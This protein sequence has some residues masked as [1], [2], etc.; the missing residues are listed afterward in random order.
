MD[1]FD[2]SFVCGMILAPAVFTMFFRNRST[3][4]GFIAAG[5]RL[6]RWLWIATAA[7]IAA[8]L[9]LARWQPGPAYFLWILFFPLWFNLAMPLLRAR[10]PGWRAPERGEV[11]SA[12]LLRRDRLQPGLRLAWFA[13]VILWA[14]L[15]VAAVAGLALGASQPPQWWLLGFS[16]L[17]GLELAVLHWA[18]RRSL[19]E[20]ETAAPGE[21][22]VLRPE[23]ESF[24]RY[25]LYGWFALAFFAMLIFSLP[26]LILIWFGNDALWWAI[27][28]GGGGGALTGIGGGVFGS[29]ASIKR[30]R[31]NRLVV[32]APARD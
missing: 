30:A 4:P 20:P 2:Y 9:L 15:L 14:L 23:R 6:N 12:S 3:E 5:K 7:G 32:E 29:I 8:F 19:I 31:I 16:L 13:L 26:P 21:S 10:D 25:K 22:D 24:F 28:I 27:S 17:A 18:M 11:R 1:W